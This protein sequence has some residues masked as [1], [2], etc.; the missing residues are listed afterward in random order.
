MSNYENQSKKIYYRPLHM[1]IEVTEKERAGWERY[2][3][4]IR[5]RNQRAGACYIPFKKSYQCDGLCDECEYR[6]K[7]DEEI[8]VFHIEQEEEY[9]AEN[10][11][12]RDS[13]LND[14]ALTTEISVDSMILRILLDKLKET[15]PENYQILMFISEGLPERVCAERLHIPRNTF[16]YRR[17][18]LLKELK[19]YF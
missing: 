3:G 1:W 11:S 5:K 15:E 8:Q 4:T 14:D 10:G 17:D 18:K 6:H 7:S 12:G 13:F 2:V 16:V 9:V 19:K